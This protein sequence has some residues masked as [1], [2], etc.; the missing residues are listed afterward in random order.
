MKKIIIALVMIVGLMLVLGSCFNDSEVAGETT[1]RLE[2]EQEAE[3]LSEEEQIKKKVNYNLQQC[4]TTYDVPK[5]TLE[6]ELKT[7]ID[8]PYRYFRKN[9]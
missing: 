9:K 3:T 1:A 4:F 8:A 5:H 6:E 2:P 7:F